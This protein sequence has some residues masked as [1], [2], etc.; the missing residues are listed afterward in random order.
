M[1]V[2]KERVLKEKKK[3]GIYEKEE[4]KELEIVKD[5]K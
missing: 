2:G 1:E 4:V 3:K 5:Q